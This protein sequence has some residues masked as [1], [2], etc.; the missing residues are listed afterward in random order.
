MEYEILKSQRMHVVEYILDSRPAVGNLG[1]ARL[2]LMARN[3]FK[4]LYYEARV[5]VIV[6][7]NGPA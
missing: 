5:L 6:I 1:P 7:H 4:T 3:S 2:N